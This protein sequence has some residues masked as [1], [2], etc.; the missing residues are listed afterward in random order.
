MTFLYILLIGLFVQLFLLPVL[1][2][3][4]HG[5]DGLL[6][7]G[8]WLD[9]QKVALELTSKIEIEGWSAWVLAPH[10]QAPAGIA[11][12]IY[13]LTGINKPWIILPLN[14]ALHASSAIVLMLIVTNV[15]GTARLSVWPVLPFIFFP[16]ALLWNTQI[17]KDGFFILGSYIFLYGFILLTQINEHRYLYRI[18][19]GFCLFLAGIGLIWIVRPYGVEM[20]VY[21]SLALALFS[22]IFLLTGL[23]KNRKIL[24]NIV[25][26]WLAIFIAMPLTQTGAHHEYVE[27][28]HAE[29]GTVESVKPLTERTV[30]EK[31][32]LEKQ[33]YYQKEMLSVEEEKLIWVHST[34]LPVFV[35]EAIYTM[36]VMRDRYRN[37]KPEARSN[38]DLDVSFNSAADAI[39]Y[40]PRA[41][42]V[43]ILAPFPNH[44]YAEGSSSL[45]TLIRRINALEMFLIYCAL[46]FMFYG[47]WIW[48]RNPQFYLAF[49][50]SLGM[51]LTYAL[52]VVNIGTLTR[53]R[54]GFIMILVAFG[55]AGL[56]ELI[57]SKYK[58][59]NS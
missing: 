14:A 27:V 37:H 18:G 11:A 52:V 49:G 33:Q 17:H 58:K 36:A 8:D 12:A 22:T 21:I 5:G 24:F 40:I 29:L 42:Q 54:Y 32:D 2:T 55:I 4:W 23:D 47:W 41:L 30:E 46:I 16:T 45:T 59:G 38:I 35:D 9:Y 28:D 53:M 56:L 44:W 6:I 13:T 57:N 43:G 50:F 10:G 26:I 3:N 34:I 7:G 19:S 15:T 48:R 39:K 20:V 1:F 31:I 51:I 25:V